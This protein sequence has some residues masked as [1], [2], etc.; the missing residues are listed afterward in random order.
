MNFSTLKDAPAFSPI[1]LPDWMRRSG[2]L[3]LVEVPRE[4]TL[5]RQLDES[6]P[7]PVITRFEMIGPAML[8]RIAPVAVIAP[9]MNARWD[10]TDLAQRL[11]SAAFCGKLLVI[12]APLPRAELVLRELCNAFPG[13]DI[14]LLEMAAG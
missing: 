1:D 5:L 4:H 3:L 2:Q 10:I 13:L 14:D 7:E 9:L 6:V 12:S 8:L 11:E